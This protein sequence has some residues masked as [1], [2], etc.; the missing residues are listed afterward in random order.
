MTLIVEVCLM[1]DERIR[2]TTYAAMLLTFVFILMAAGMALQYGQIKP[3]LDQHHTYRGYENGGFEQTSYI[4]Q[5]YSKA[6]TTYN[7]TVNFLNDSSYENHAFLAFLNIFNNA[8]RHTFDS[9]VKLT[10]RDE[11]PKTS[12]RV[13]I[14]ASIMYGAGIPIM[15][16]DMYCMSAD[17]SLSIECYVKTSHFAG[18]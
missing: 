17:F 16:E 8:A 14:F 5:T 15:P 12:N 3:Y 10:A 1:K 6:Q 4:L 7:N 11:K 13:K 2:L 18:G 9:S